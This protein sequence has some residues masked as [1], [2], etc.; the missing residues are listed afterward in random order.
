MSGRVLFF[1]VV[2]K[3]RQARQSQV[4]V[5]WYTGPTWIFFLGSLGEGC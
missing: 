2:V 4:L 3:A 5:T 1:E